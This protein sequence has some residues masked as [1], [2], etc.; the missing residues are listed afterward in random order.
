MNA[1]HFLEIKINIFVK[2]KNV[3]K[4]LT[5]WSPSSPKSKAENP[6]TAPNI[7]VT[8]AG[9]YVGKLITE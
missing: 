2:N 7:D 4:I 9:E 8:I 5:I 1:V 3:H 6:E